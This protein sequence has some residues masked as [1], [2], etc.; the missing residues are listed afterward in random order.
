M[1]TANHP[2]SAWD[3]I[4]TDSTMTV[5]AVDRLVHHAVMLEI[6]A[7]S[8]RQQAAKQRALADDKKWST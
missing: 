4:F 5:A 6:Q 1:I 7:E 2:F 3:H 8:F